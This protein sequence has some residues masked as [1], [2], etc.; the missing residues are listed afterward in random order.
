MG[1]ALKLIYRGDGCD[2]NQ[3]ESISLVENWQ[4]F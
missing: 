4:I 3:N 1:G 2:A